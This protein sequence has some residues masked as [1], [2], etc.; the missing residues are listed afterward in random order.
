MGSTPRATTRSWAAGPSRRSPRRSTGTPHPSCC[1][2]SALPPY[3]WSACR[4]RSR[5]S[6]HPR[7]RRARSPRAALSVSAPVG[8]S[9]QRR[10]D[11]PR[12]PPPARSLSA[13][14]AVWRAEAC[15]LRRSPRRRRRPG[16]PGPRSIAWPSRAGPWANGNSRLRGLRARL[17]E[18]RR[19]LCTASACWF[20]SAGM[21]A[22]AFWTLGTR[23]ARRPGRSRPATSGCAAAAA[24]THSRATARGTP[25]RIAGHATRVRSRG[26]G[27]ERVCST[28]C[29]RG[30]CCSTG[31][32]RR[33][34]G[35]AHM[36]A[37]AVEMLWRDWR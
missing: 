5:R 16:C 22:S 10:C 36:R 19:R 6:R 35:R 29:G 20:L 30:K 21:D 2:S 1:C 17:R 14:P 23:R 11:R 33:M 3:R 4:G 15:R 37:G 9:R 25:T 31:S 18:R 26:A 8:R 34:N 7:A 24:R 27:A 12:R 28:R 32:R 13:A